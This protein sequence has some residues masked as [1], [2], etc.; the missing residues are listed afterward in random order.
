MGLGD[1]P[2]AEARLGLGDESP[3]PSPLP[4][5]RD[6]NPPPGSLV[7][8]VSR[9]HRHLPPG[10]AGA[11]AKALTRRVPPARRKGAQAV[12]ARPPGSVEAPARA[13]SPPTSV[14]R[15]TGPSAS[16]PGASE[17]ARALGPFLSG[18]R[19]L[20][21]APCVSRGPTSARGARPLPRVGPRS[22]GRRSSRSSRARCAP[23]PLP[24]PGPGGR[25]SP[26]S[27]PDAGRERLRARRTCGTR[28]RLQVAPSDRLRS[29]SGFR[30]PPA[31]T[32]LR[33]ASLPDR[34]LGHKARGGRAAGTTSPPGARR[35][36]RRQP[37]SARPAA[38]PGLDRSSVR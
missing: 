38:A 4:I 5:P 26:P 1:H 21:G 35:A 31:R 18:A 12:G 29:R 14:P 27:P 6:Q 33:A 34:G 10:R 23:R 9:Q 17:G 2:G 36:G 30:P 25:V 3:E 37:R 19:S 24:G 20:S 13:G 16:H 32:R 22:P 7:L 8:A 28:G 15:E 11:A